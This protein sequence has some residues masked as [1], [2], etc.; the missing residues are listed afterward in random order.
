MKNDSPSRKVQA[1]STIDGCKYI[2]I[3]FVRGSDRRT[4]RLKGCLC[5]S[6]KQNSSSRKMFH[7]FREAYISGKYFIVF[8][9]SPR[10]AGAR[11]M[12]MKHTYSR[13]RYK[14]YISPNAAF[15]SIQFSQKLFDDVDLWLLELKIKSISCVC[16]CVSVGVWALASS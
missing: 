1:A 8:C 5:F 15:T 9:H 14:I 3:F 2:Q 13:R 16:E 10:R 7:Y 4:D 6:Q 11:D 12:H